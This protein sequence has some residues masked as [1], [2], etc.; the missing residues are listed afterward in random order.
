MLADEVVLAVLAMVTEV[1]SMAGVGFT[2]ESIPQSASA[3]FMPYFLAASHDPCT[4]STRSHHLAQSGTI[5]Q[6][7]EWPWMRMSCLLAQW[8]T[9]SELVVLVDELVLVV[10]YGTAVV[11]VVVVVVLVV[12]VGLDVVVV[13]VVVGLVV[14]VDPPS[15]IPQ[16]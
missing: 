8:G 1:V 9:G 14:V 16:S 15:T 5:F 12:V 6:S 4:S 2:S 13:V 10:V 7:T 11:A 3:V